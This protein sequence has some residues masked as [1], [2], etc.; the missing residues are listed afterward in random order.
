[1]GS[2]RRDAAEGRLAAGTTIRFSRTF[3]STEVERFGETTRDANPVHTD[4]RWCDLK[5][6]RGPI[7]HGLL[8]GSMVCEPGGQWGWLASGM[9]FRFL[10]PVYIGDTVTCEMTIVELDERRFARAEAVLT[11]QRG[12]VVLTAELRG[13][14]PGA[15]EQA[16]LADLVGE[17]D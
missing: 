6:Y 10:R 7:C 16:V 14:L 5:G 9:S 15:A 1:M 8:I 3:T 11:N 4:Q 12:E 2:W 13:Y 17:A